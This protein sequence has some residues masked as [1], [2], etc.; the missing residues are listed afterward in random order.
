MTFNI[1]DYWVLVEYFDNLKK[2]NKKF[3]NIDSS[4]YKNK[5][6]EYKIFI[7]DNVHWQHRKEYLTLMTDFLNSKITGVEFEKSF[8]ALHQENEKIVRK[9]EFDLE[10]L[11]RF[12]FDLRAAG[13]TAWTSELELGCDE[14]FPDLITEEAP[15]LF[16]GFARDEND[17][18]NFVASILPNIQPYL[19]E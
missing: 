12:P 18:R 16:F 1:N 15:H 3:D 10:K 9:I 13:F 17:F 7:S 6:Q 2:I 11:K 14:F 19:E 8:T 5:L 4:L